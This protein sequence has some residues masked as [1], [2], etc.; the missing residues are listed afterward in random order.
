MHYTQQILS[1]AGMIN[2]AHN[3]KSDEIKLKRILRDRFLFI[4]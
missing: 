3:H 2:R 1:V 4:Y